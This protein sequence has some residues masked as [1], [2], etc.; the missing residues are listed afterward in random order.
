MITLF[1]IQLIKSLLYYFLKK[2]EIYKSFLN[3][4][5]LY[6]IWGRPK[7]EIF[8]NWE[9]KL[10]KEIKK[11]NRSAA[12]ELIEIYYTEIFRYCC[13]HTY[14][15]EQAEDAT[16]E[17]FLKFIR[18]IDAYKHQGMLRAFLYRIA[19]NTC[20]DLSRKKDE[21]MFH[22]INEMISESSYEEIGFYEIESNEK[23]QKIINVL[24]INQRELI[25]LRYSQELTLKEISE[26]TGE[27]LRTVQSGIR[28]ALKKI[29]K[30]IRKENVNE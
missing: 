15:R 1:F 24:P 23:F 21:Q 30:E 18:Y 7:E 11:G 25:I 13:W 8:L 3:P 28:S 10:C 19:K 6:Y 17:T 5:T 20:V 22:D 14:S 12:N 4:N 2:T 27:K 26:V 29:E 16:Q 9:E